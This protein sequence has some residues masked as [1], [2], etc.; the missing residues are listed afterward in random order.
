[1]IAHTTLLLFCIGIF[2][3]IKYGIKIDKLVSWLVLAF[4]L[5]IF[6]NFCLPEKAAISHIFNF[7]W[8]TAKDS[9]LSIDIVSNIY[10][11]TLILPFFA[12]TILSVVHN[13]IFNNEKKLNRY[14]SALILNL[15][16]LILLITSNNF[17]QLLFSLFVIDIISMLI[18][19]TPHIYRRYLLLNM[20]TDLI[21]LMILAII[22]CHVESLDISQILLYKRIGQYSD[23]VSIMGS[24]AIFAKL[25]FLFFQIG[26][27]NLKQIPFHRLQ[28]IIFLSSPATALILLLKF[29]TLWHISEY[30]TIYL[31][32]ACGITAIWAFFG[33]IYSGNFKAK[34]IYWQILFFTVFVEL[35]RFQGFIWTE[36]SSYLLLEMYIIVTCLYLIYLVNNR[37]NSVSQMINTNLKHKKDLFITLFFIVIDILAM[38]NTLVLMYNSMN[39][40]YIWTFATLFISS[41]T[42][43]IWQIYF[44]TQ[45]WKYILQNK[46]ILPHTVFAEIFILLTIVLIPLQSQ[47]IIIWTIPILFM[48]LCKFSPLY[49]TTLLYSISTLQNNDLLG[50]I[51]HILISSIKL[52]GRIFWIL[53]NHI[54][55]EKI[56]L[57][58]VT[59]F[60]QKGFYFFRRL[61]NNQFSGGITV[62]ILLLMLCWF[63]YY[64]GSIKP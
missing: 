47:R 6:G 40:Y 5:I 27:M 19:K 44:S 22:N 12:I 57:G 7:S 55:I 9:Q 25:S 34:I 13:Y 10:N 43:I 51:Y 30:F 63:S 8:N 49:K 61:H 37:N 53:I 1:M 21:F 56:I 62:I 14:N 39:R 28:N 46:I 31:D 45:R 2:S 58:N 54:V 50:Y 29:N 59:S 16:A 32:I 64:Q 33:S 42:T 36:N 17:V 41:L 38:S 35:L 11:H 20:F 18:I 3:Y 52:C 4:L 15:V 48:I 23:F 26:I 60:I 24:T